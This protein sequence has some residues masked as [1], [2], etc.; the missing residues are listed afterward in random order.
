ME[1]N[2]VPGKGL[3]I[4]SLILGIVALITCFCG[5]LWPLAGVI[6]SIVGLVLAGSAKKAGNTT[7]LRTAGFVISLI[8]LIVSALIFV[9]AVVIAG[10]L[11]SAL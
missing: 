9:I 11:L 8:A 4:A 10:L 2:T 7:G 1:T 5:D 6:L 3:S